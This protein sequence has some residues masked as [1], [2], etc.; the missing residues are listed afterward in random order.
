[1]LKQSHLKKILDYDSLTGMFVWKETKA[2]RLIGKIAGTPNGNGYI[3]ICIDHKKYY[4]HTLAYLYIYGDIPVEVDHINGDREDNR[5]AN[6]REVDRS[7]NNKNTTMYKNNKSGV[8]G[9]YYNKRNR[10]WIAEVRVKGTK[11]HLGTFET[12]V[13]AKEARIH[14]NRLYNFHVNHGKIQNKEGFRDFT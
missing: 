10:N 8:L 1:M 2:K 5:I 6:L 4:A 14:A 11:I 3:R 13:L 9:V 12:I 7:E